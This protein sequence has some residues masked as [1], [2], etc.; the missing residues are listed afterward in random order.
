MRRVFSILVLVPLCALGL[1]AVDNAKLLDAATQ[2]VRSMTTGATPIPSSLLRDAKCIAVI[3]KLTKGG[4]IVG[5]EH[6]NGAVSCRTASGWSAPAFITITGGSVGLQA[7]GEHQEIVLLMNN[8]G[9]QELTNG[10][11]DLGAE[12]V[13][14]GPTGD[15][16]SASEST[17]WKAPVLSYSHSSGAYAGA[18]LQGSKID[19]D[20]DANH[21]LYGP[22][23]SIKSILDGQ[24]QAPEAAHRFLSALEQVASK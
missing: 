19:L 6:G 21:N 17:G 11:W 3:P 15:S 14:A 2:T 7:G 23:A 8:Q 4:F 16:A 22:N 24:A 5:G 1:W 18:N 13:A 12:A 9:K 20:H 10:H